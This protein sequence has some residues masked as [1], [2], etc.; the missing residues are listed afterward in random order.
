MLACL[1]DSGKLGT[2]WVLRDKLRQC[3]GVYLPLLAEHRDLLGDVL[4]LS[5]VARPL[6]LHQQ[7][8]GLVGERYFGQLVLLCRLQGEEAEEQG[9]VLAALAQWRHLDG[10][11]VEAIVEVF[12][13]LAFADGLAHIDVGG[14][15]N[16]D[17]CLH[18][19][20]SSHAYVFACFENAEQSCLCGHWQLA[21]LVEE[22]CALVGNAEVAF[23]FA[24]GAG[25]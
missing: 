23:A 22:Y 11:G 7:E 3:L 15:D 2:L 18:Y 6:V 10:D 1:F 5:H 12:A 13:E 16:S 17:V 21:N 19:L 14:S 4:E 24:D 20:L 8:L 25:E 9:D